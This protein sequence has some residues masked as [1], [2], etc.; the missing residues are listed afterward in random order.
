MRAP[1]LLSFLSKRR[2]LFSIADFQEDVGDDGIE[3]R[4]IDFKH[5]YSE[6]P[7]MAVLL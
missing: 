5:V 6:L 7:N 2:V 3:G 4:Y 1:N